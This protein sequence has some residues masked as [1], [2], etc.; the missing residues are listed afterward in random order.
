MPNKIQLNLRNI[1]KEP[2][3]IF[4]L[5][6]FSGLL[7]K[8]SQ[9][10]YMD[11]AGVAEISA[12]L[13]ALYGAPLGPNSSWEDVNDVLR[14]IGIPYRLEENDD[15]P[16]DI[17]LTAIVDEGKKA[18]PMDL[19][20]FNDLPVEAYVTKFHDVMSKIFIGTTSA[21]VQYS[22]LME[23]VMKCIEFLISKNPKWD[24][25]QIGQDNDA[26]NEFMLDH[27]FPYR[28]SRVDHIDGSGSYTFTVKHNDANTMFHLGKLVSC[29]GDAASRKVVMTDEEFD[30]FKSNVA[31]L[32]FQLTGYQVIGLKSAD[33][34]QLNIQLRYFGLPY[35]VEMFKLNLP[36]EMGRATYALRS[37]LEDSNY[38]ELYQLNSF[39]KCFID[40]EG[41]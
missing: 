14:Y 26:F 29:L 15:P 17:V 37:K 34:R 8:D 6:E 21:M 3:R 7:W 27:G 39:V 28:I 25:E 40:E 20:T 9:K 1:A 30:Q 38:L 16:H 2:S 11:P 10:S 31:D 41:L 36:G 5:G 32:L 18:T 12:H 4:M 33:Y 24:R 22:K 19:S 13:T 35:T 23:P